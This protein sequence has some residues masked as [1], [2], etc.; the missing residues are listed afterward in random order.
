MEGEVILDH[1]QGKPIGKQEVRKG[2][3]VNFP[4]CDVWI[5]AMA[6]SKHISIM[7]NTR[8]T[9]NATGKKQKRRVGTQL[10][11]IEYGEY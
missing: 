8:G 4:S 9:T 3:S 7:A 10:V 1:M 5:G 6:D 2:K 11:E